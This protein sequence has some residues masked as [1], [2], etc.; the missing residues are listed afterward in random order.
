MDT[1]PVVAIAVLVFAAALLYSSVGHAGASG[2]LAVLALFGLTPALMKPTALALNILVAAIATVK[3]YRA[4]CFSWPLFLPFALASVPFAC[5]GGRLT[6]P[7][8]A[9]KPLVGAVL[10]YAAWRSLREAGK[11][12]ATEIKPPPLTA[13]A[14]SGAGLG[15]LSGLTGVG[16]GIFLSP[17]LIFMGWAETRMVSGVA[18]AFIL[19]NSVA[20]LLGV[21]SSS[22]PALPAYLPAMAVAAAA[23]GLVGSDYG[24]R[25]LG[26]PAIKRLLSVVLAVAGIKMVMT[27]W[28]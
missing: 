24:S 26:S 12:Q 14:L 8:V 27:A 23:G 28:S 19:V 3:Y 10:L 22:G 17:L 15:F 5:L 2:Y 9:Y 13:A 20:G 16:G 18:A 7:G 25:R 6:L 21:A 11:P 4:G 1:E